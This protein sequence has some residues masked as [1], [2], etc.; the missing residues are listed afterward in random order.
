MRK[1]FRYRLFPTP[2]QRQALQLQL[3]A[4]RFV[5]NK[6]L[7]ARKEAWKQRQESI[8]R[9]D[10]VNMLPQ[11]KTEY[12]WLQGGH[13]EAMQETMIRLD[14]AFRAF[15]R[16][17]KAGEKPGYPRFR[18]KDRY[19]SFTYPRERGNWRF[20]ADG[21][22]RL[23]KIGPV[24]IKLHRPLEGTP[25]TLTI[26][27]DAVGNW[28]AYF[29]CI[30]EPKLLPVSDEMVGIDLGLKTFAVLSNG[31]KIPRQ[32]WMKRDT[33][34]IARL[35]RKKERLAKGSAERRKAIH[36]L[37]H[38]YQRQTNRRN[39]F[40]HQESRKLVNRYGLLVFEKLDIRDMQS[41][42]NHAVNRGIA[43]V[44]WGK[45]VQYTTYKAECAGRGMLLVNPRGTTQEC[46]GCGAV[47]P[48]DLSVRVHDCPHCGLKLDRDLNAA[49]NVLT[50]GLASLGASP[51]SS[52]IYQGE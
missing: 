38:A 28:Y 35:Q 20:L 15:F 8:S 36:A 5:Y 31:E 10:T 45:F 11:W 23:S 41:N 44:A 26:R 27:R 1:T 32:R 49:R 14:L 16:R 17:C 50:R 37:Q 24:K 43:D 47:V 12:P 52:S 40:A 22:L 30:A 39:D 33:K 3:D 51:G 2:A 9:F 6:A 19:D 4:C 25:K 18:G 21:R 34:D 29:S 7:E 46:S 42:G 13:A 48:K